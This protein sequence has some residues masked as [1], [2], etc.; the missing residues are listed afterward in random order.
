MVTIGFS[1]THLV[2]EDLGGISIVV[3]VLMN[4]L[5]RDVSLTF[6]TVDD[7]ARGKVCTMCNLHGSLLTIYLFLPACS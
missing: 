3:F 4:S 2:H 5:A 7:T 1:G 6:S